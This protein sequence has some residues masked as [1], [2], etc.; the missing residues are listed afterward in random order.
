MERKDVEALVEKAQSDPAFRRALLANPTGTVAREL[1]VD[2]PAG[3][4]VRVLEETEREL[5]LV[6]PLPAPDTPLDDSQ[7]DAVAGGRQTAATS[8]GVIVKD[9]LGRE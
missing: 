8:F 5:Y 4:K 7:L 9:G 2:F 3:V 6:L 1:N